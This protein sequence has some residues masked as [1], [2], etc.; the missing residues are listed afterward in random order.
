MINAVE[1]LQ[2]SKRNITYTHLASDAINKSLV[3]F[4]S[5]EQIPGFDQKPDWNRHSH[6]VILDITINLLLD[7]N[8]HGLI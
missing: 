8:F 5:A 1:S 4:S 7:D 3:I 2:K 6:P